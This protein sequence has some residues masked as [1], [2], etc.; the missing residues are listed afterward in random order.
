MDYKLTVL[1]EVFFCRVVI[2]DSR[3]T[4]SL[5]KAPPQLLHDQ[6]SALSSSSVFKATDLRK[7]DIKVNLINSNRTSFFKKC[8]KNQKIVLKIKTKVSISIQVFFFEPEY[9]CLFF[10]VTRVY[11]SLYHFVNGFFEIFPYAILRFLSLFV[12]FVM[13][14]YF[15]VLL[16]YHSPDS[17]FVVQYFFGNQGKVGIQRS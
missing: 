2:Q 10:F 16:R 7:D 1:G 12:I 13:K 15:S 17:K 5:M 4:H 8:R 14:T 9:I 6:V 11:L 3:F